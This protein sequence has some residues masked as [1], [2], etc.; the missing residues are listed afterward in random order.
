MVD[1]FLSFSDQDRDAAITLRNLLRQEGLSVFL[2]HPDLFTRDE[3]LDALRSATCVVVV[4][5]FK[6]TT[7]A[8]GAVVTSSVPRAPP[9]L[10]RLRKQQS[11]TRLAQIIQ[12]Q[13]PQCP[14]IMCRGRSTSHSTVIARA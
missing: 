11:C 14:N 1:V 7:V 13:F 4:S 3:I 5:T 10:A 2:A 9:P 8:P 12:R 6:H